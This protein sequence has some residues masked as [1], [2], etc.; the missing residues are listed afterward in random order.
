MIN[1]LHCE[2]LREQKKGKHH[3]DCLSTRSHCIHITTTLLIHMFISFAETELLYY[4]YQ[5]YCS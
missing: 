5:S 1:S 2:R 4:T 3:R